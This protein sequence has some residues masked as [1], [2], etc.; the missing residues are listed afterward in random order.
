MFSHRPLCVKR[1]FQYWFSSA[2]Y[3]SE[4]IAAVSDCGN[5]QQNICRLPQL[6]CKKPWQNI[7]SLPHGLGGGGMGFGQ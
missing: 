3:F 7:L 6:F 5:L 2:K 1:W 4:L